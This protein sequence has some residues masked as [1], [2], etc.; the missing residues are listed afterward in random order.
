M[1]FAITS[2]A[3]TK[4]EAERFLDTL[5]LG[6]TYL[7]GNKYKPFNLTSLNGKNYSQE[8][9][10]GKITFIDF[11]F[12]SCSPCIA[13][14]NALENLYENFCVYKN[15]QFLSITYE[16]SETIKR[17]LKK[18]KMPYPIINTS[19][20]SCINLNFGKGFP[21]KIIVGEDGEILYFSFGGDPDIDRSDLY[22]KTNLYPLLNCLLNCN[23]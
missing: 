6:G 5:K 12:E 22:F 15:F 21:A 2:S 17:L 7:V 9:L 4:D 19:L 1:V 13:E 16:T 11:W 20:D 10:K 18:Y 3:Q 8:S 14:M 23:H